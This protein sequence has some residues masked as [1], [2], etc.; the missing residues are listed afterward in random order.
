MK[1]VFYGGVTA[2]M[3]SREYYY[4]SGVGPDYDHWT[5]KGK[6][7]LHAYLEVMAPQIAVVEANE[8]D[9]RAKELVL[10]ELKES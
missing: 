1:D 5:E 6:E 3:D 9:R 4:K 10:K 8:L 2:L 7:A